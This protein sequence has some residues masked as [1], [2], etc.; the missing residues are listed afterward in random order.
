MSDAPRYG[1]REAHVAEVVS[2]HAGH[3]AARTTFEDV[4]GCPYCT[5]TQGERN[6]AVAAIQATKRRNRAEGR[7]A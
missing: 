2:C 6:A 1:T 5:L 7:N 3:L 4:G